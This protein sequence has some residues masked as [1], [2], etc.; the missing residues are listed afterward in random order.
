MD[1]LKYLPSIKSSDQSSAPTTLAD[2]PIQSDVPPSSNS[3]M[4]PVSLPSTDQ[5]LLTA[6]TIP[7]FS[8]GSLSGPSNTTPTVTS[9]SYISS[10]QTLDPE[11]SP[12]P[13]HAELEPSPIVL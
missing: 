6:Q 11:V 12:Q 13:P 10:P 7:P 4:P 9:P 5:H 8:L 1:D 3:S 2:V